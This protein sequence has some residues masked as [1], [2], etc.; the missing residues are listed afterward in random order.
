LLGQAC[1]CRDLAW[2]TLIHAGE[3]EERDHGSGDVWVP[4]R[5]DAG[6]HFSPSEVVRET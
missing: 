3:S 4:C 1:C 2:P 5:V 6:Q